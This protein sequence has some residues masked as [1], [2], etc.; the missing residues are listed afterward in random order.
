MARYA[1][2]FIPGPPV[3]RRHTGD[4]PLAGL[5]FCAKDVFAIAGHRTSAG[6]PR[7]AETH[8]AAEHDAEVIA[9]LRAAGADL[10]GVTVLDELAFGLTGQNPHHGTPD[11]PRA[12]GRLCGGS[13][14]GS[15]AAA[16]AGLC[17]FALGT[18]TLGSVRLP[19]S[20][21][22]LFGLRPTHARISSRGVVP[23]APSFDT[24]G[25]LA[26]DAVVLSRVGG[27]LLG[28][29][30]Q[31]IDVT[32]LVVP[33]ELLSCMD[34]IARPALE[35][36]LATLAARLGA[37]L[38]R[39]ELAEGRLQDWAA[40]TRRLQAREVWSTH[41]DW[42]IAQRP[43]FGP[44]VKERF[45]MSARLAG[46]SEAADSDRDLRARVRARLENLTE[47]ERTLVALPRP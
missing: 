34:P 10:E 14:A 19:A 47:G 32:T 43:A 13:S 23:L 6:H 39:M 12:P 20:F 29:P 4:G 45:E 25:W 17:D 41:G 33:D 18:D 46:S 7:W 11:N 2:I 35:R 26:R 24:V 40:A 1:G 15:A 44:G 21:C 16:A 30:P 27:V 28:E 36:K 9:Q 37:K 31:S 38:A 42:V 5:R 8:P 22:G 3:A